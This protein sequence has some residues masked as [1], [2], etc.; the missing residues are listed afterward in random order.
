MGKKKSLKDAFSS[1]RSDRSRPPPGPRGHSYRSRLLMSTNEALQS[2]SCCFLFQLSRMDGTKAPTPPDST[3]KLQEG[4]P[5]T[6]NVSN[7]QVDP[8]S[9]TAQK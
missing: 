4:C 5:K 1:H 6:K 9:Y 8:K 3:F 7:I 2:G